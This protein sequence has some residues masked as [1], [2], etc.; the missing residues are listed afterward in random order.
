MNKENLQER[1]N[2]LSEQY[3]DLLELLP[4]HKYSKA[5]TPPEW[6]ADEVA[7]NTLDKEETKELIQDFI[8]NA[9]DLEEMVELLT[10]YFLEE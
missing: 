9:S 10:E 8:E 2:E 1:Y 6:V 4:Q 3:E 5:G 7:A